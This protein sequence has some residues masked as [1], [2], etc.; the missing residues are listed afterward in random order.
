MID[1]KDGSIIEDLGYDPY[2]KSITIG[3]RG[4]FLINQVIKYFTGEGEII[5]SNEPDKVYT[6]KVINQIDYNRLLRYRTAVVTFRVQ[7]YKHKHLEAYK[8]AQTATATGTNI[9]LADSGAT[10]LRVATEAETVIVHGKNLFNPSSLLV[11]TN[12]NLT[13]RENGYEV[14]A[15]GGAGSSYAVSKYSLPLSMRG[16]EYCIKCDNFLREQNIDAVAQVVVNTE[17]QTHYHAVSVR[18]QAS[19]FAVPQ[20]AT[21]IYVGIWTNN[22]SQKLT[23][24]NVV[25]IYGLRITAVEHSSDAWCAFDGLQT[26]EVV[27]GV[28]NANGYD[29]VTVISNAENADMAVAYTKHFE[30]FNEGLESSKPVMVL[31]GSGMVSISVNGVLTFTYTY[32]D[33]E[34]EVV[35]DSEKED[36]YLGNV[37]KNRNMNGEFP[38]LMSGTN[39]IEWS[40]DVESIEILP[41]S[42]WL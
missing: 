32:P 37:L 23:Y 42:R 30:V 12:A 26:L 9:V 38:V 41:R 29:S 22:T 2:T 21:S 15:V 11:N 28:A 40:G 4:N 19:T 27:D 7:P 34:N 1:G 33:G 36:A 35:I 6:A 17:T 20:D 18:S 39:K 3:L 16:K 10:P 8:E 5:F 13:I 14:V 31:R 25:K 24:D